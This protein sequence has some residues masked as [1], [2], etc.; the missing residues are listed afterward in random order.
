M[1]FSHKQDLNRLARGLRRVYRPIALAVGIFA[2]IFGLVIILLDQPGEP[3]AALPQ[4]DVSYSCPEGASLNILA[5]PLIKVTGNDDGSF[6]GDFVAGFNSQ[7]SGA[8]CDVLVTL[9]SSS[10]YEKDPTKPV[11][12]GSVIADEA[13]LYSTDPNAQRAGYID[14]SFTSSDQSSWP[15]GLGVRTF[16]LLI[17]TGMHGKP[18]PLVTSPG[19][20]SRSLDLSESCPSGYPQVSNTYPS[21]STLLSRDTASWSV[22]QT[23]NGSS[24]TA[25]C[26]NAEKRFW[27]DHASDAMVLGLG[28]LLTVMVEK[29][30][31][32]ES[33]VPQRGPTN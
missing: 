19:E 21:S 33:P 22:E 13:P 7:G 11:V 20:P 27:V 4:I 32:E 9:P 12:Q 17:S 25:V 16:D 1:R 30:K 28:L 3:S 2:I 8:L 6:S 18:L 29:R 14:Y 26:Q 5:I 10:N 23:D 24:Y 31:K 15:D